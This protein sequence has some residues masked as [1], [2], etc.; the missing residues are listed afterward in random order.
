MGQSQRLH[1]TSQVRD[2]DL[3]PVMGGGCLKGKPLQWY[4]GQLFHSG[5]NLL[6]HRLS[7]AP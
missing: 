1:G 7:V 6:C 3:Y 5:D 4:S 2:D